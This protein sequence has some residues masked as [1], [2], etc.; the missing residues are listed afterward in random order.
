[1]ITWL[2][3]SYDSYDLI[4]TSEQN[5]NRWLDV[6]TMAIRTTGERAKRS[7]KGAHYRRVP[8]GVQLARFRPLVLFFQRRV[9]QSKSTS[10]D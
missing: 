6:N 2:T 9:G 8:F 10:F 1:M 5:S 4:K 7:T 3:I